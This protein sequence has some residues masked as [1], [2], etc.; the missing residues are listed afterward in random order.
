MYIL[1]QFSPSSLCKCPEKA[2]DFTFVAL[3]K[4]IAGGPQV[5]QPRAALLR[6]FSVAG[7]LGILPNLH[8]YR[9]RHRITAS[10]CRISLSKGAQPVVSVI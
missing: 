1:P 10:L 9:Y 8:H 6:V 5:P 7:I 4:L 2:L 3:P